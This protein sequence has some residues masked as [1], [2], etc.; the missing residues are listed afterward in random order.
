MLRVWLMQ[1]FLMLFRFLL[2]VLTLGVSRKPQQ[3]LDRKLQG[4]GARP[5]LFREEPPVP[6]PWSLLSKHVVNPQ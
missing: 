6:G 2:T 3:E 5:V 1:L 4:A